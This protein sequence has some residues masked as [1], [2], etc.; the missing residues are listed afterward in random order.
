MSPSSLT[1]SIARNIRLGLCFRT[2]G[3]ALAGLS[4]AHFWAIPS[5]SAAERYAALVMDAET[6]DV[7]EARNA[8]EARYPASITKVMTLYLLFDALDKGDVKYSSRVVFSRRAAGASPTKLGVRAGQSISVEEAIN[9]LIVKSANDVAIAVAE[10]L[11]GS[12][13]AFAQRMTRKARSLGMQDTTF[14][15]ASGLPNSRQ[16]TTAHDL[17]ILAQ[18]MIREHASYYSYF[19]TPSFRFRKT[20]VPTHNRLLNSVDGVDGLKTGY[21]VASGYNLLTSAVREGQRLIF[22]V[23]G[24]PSASARDFHMAQLI[25]AGFLSARALR[26]QPPEIAL[27]SF[28]NIPDL[29]AGAN[30]LNALQLASVPGSVPNGALS[31]SHDEIGAGDTQSTDLDPGTD[32]AEAEGDDNYLGDANQSKTDLAR[33][34]GASIDPM[35]DYGV[36]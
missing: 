15:N 2:T 24:G 9:A 28:R 6:G 5:A 27:A 1:P 20:V 7:L 3:I 22:V 30:N 18:A 13:S 25:E 35:V 8:D 12:E 32:N 11:A 29:G 21:T 14:V 26:T 10:K 33:L 16:V 4:V 36:Y 34:S 31:V 23:L 17:G 19:S